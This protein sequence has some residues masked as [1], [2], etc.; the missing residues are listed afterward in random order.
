MF[1]LLSSSRRVGQHRK[2]SPEPTVADES[3]ISRL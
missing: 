1:V 2:R 3:A